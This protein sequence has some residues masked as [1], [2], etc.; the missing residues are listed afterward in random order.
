MKLLLDTCVFLWL[1]TEPSKLSQAA[2]TALDDEQNE[3]FLSDVSIWE[4]TLKYKAGK[5]PLPDTPRR[6]IPSE[7]L[8]H[9]IQSVSIVLDAMF[10][11]SELPG[12]HRDPFDRLIGAQAEVGAFRLVSPDD[13][14]T[15]LGIDRLW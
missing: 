1:A 2:T 12:D 13:A 4:I 15:T 7:L 9:G 3:L 10:L 14:F 11:A 8:F 5:L 6:W